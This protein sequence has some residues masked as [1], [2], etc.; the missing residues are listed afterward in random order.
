MNGRCTLCS[1]HVPKNESAWKQHT[2]GERK[3]RESTLHV[4]HADVYKYFNALSCDAM[5]GWYLWNKRDK[6]FPLV[7]TVCLHDIDHCMLYVSG[8][9]HRRNLLSY[10]VHGEPGHAVVSVFE[11]PISLQKSG[12][13]ITNDPAVVH[14]S[15]QQQQQAQR[16]TSHNEAST[17]STAPSQG[18]RH[19]IQRAMKAH[20]TNLDR[21]T[22]SRSGSSLQY[23]QQQLLKQLANQAGLGTLY[24]RASARFSLECLQTGCMKV[25]ECLVL[26][27]GPGGLCSVQVDLEH[28]WGPAEIAALAGMLEQQHLRCHNIHVTGE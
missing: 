23:L 1:C 2:S 15:Q 3:P 24:H 25:R 26:P 28:A 4:V 14:S 22:S 7:M 16:R 19:S 9:R 27:L 12:N 21:T 20:D 11:D 18:G 13:Y 5:L 17:S 8:I 6:G 10:R